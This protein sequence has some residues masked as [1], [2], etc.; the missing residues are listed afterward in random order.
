LPIPSW[1]GT[2]HGRTDFRAPRL[3]FCAFRFRR[4]AHVVARFASFAAARAR[5]IVSLVMTS[6]DH[7]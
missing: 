5:P 4:I 6:Y 1:L 3:N 2:R 7:P